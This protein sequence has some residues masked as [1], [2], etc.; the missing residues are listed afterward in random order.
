MRHTIIM[1]VIVS[2]HLAGSCS[3]LSYAADPSPAA[4]GQK[5]GNDVT[6]QKDVSSGNPLEEFAKSFGQ[7]VKSYAENNPGGMEQLADRY[8][9]TPLHS[10]A[11]GNKT[12]E[13]KRLLA[14]GADANARDFQ[15]STPLHYAAH[16][17]GADVIP[18]LLAAGADV[19]A[20]DQ[21]GD[22]P[23]HLAMPIDG[24]GGE[25]A[26]PYLLKG[27]ADV[28]AVDNDG[29]TP[30]LIGCSYSNLY[31]NKIKQLIAAGADVNRRSKNGFSPLHWA[32]CRH[33]ELVAVLIAAGAD[34]NAKDEEGG[35]PLHWAALHTMPETVE[36]LLKAKA[37]PNARDK[38][39]WSPLAL[40]ADNN[41]AEIVAVLRQAGGREE[42][43]TK[44][45]QAAVFEKP[46]KLAELL[47]GKPAVNATDVYG[48]TPLQWAL[49]CNDDK[50]ADVLIAA[51]ADLTT[52]DKQHK[53]ILQVAVWASRIDIVKKAIAAGADVNLADDDGYTALHF[54]ITSQNAEIVPLLLEKHAKV[55]L[56][57][58]SGDTPLLRAFPF[59]K[60]ELINKLLDAGADVQAVNNEGKSVRGQLWTVHDEKLRDRLEKAVQRAREE[61]IEAICRLYSA[62]NPR[63]DGVCA[64]TP[65]AAA[66]KMY[67]A[68][69]GPNRKAFLAMFVGQD[70]DMAAVNA[71][72]EATHAYLA[73]RAELTKA[74]GPDAWAKFDALKMA[75]TEWTIT[76]P[77]VADEAQLERM[78]V[79]VQGDQAVCRQFPQ[80]EKADVRFV[81]RD[82]VW[83]IDAGF[84][85]PILQPGAILR[86]LSI[87]S[88][89][90]QKGRVVIRQSNRQ[91][92]DVKRA[93]WKEFKQRH[94]AG[95]AGRDFDQQIADGTEAIRLDPKS[96]DAY[97]RRADSYLDKGDLDKALADYSEAIHLDPQ[98]TG[99]FIDRA[100]I[101]GIK[102]DC[103]RAM[104]DAVEAVRIDPTFAK[105][106]NALGIAYDGY[107]RKMS[108]LDAEAAD[109]LFD[110][111]AKTFGGPPPKLD[112]APRLL[113]F[114][115]FRDEDFKVAARKL[116]RA[117]KV[118]LLFDYSA[119]AYKAAIDIKPDYD[120]GNNNLGVYYARRGGLDDMKLAEKYLRAALRSNP[121]YADACNNLGIVLARQGKLDEA[122]AAHKT[123]LRARND[124]ASDH[125]NL[126]RVY[127][128]KGDLDSASQ[129]NTVSLR[130]DPNF[131]GAW[132][133]RAELGIKRKDVD[134]AA[135]CVHRMMAIDVKAPQTIQAE[136]LVAGVYLD[137][138][139]PE[140]A[141]DFLGDFLKHNPS[142]PDIYNA[143]GIAYLQKGDLIH[144][145]NDFEQI[146]RIRPNH[147]DAQK[148]LDAIQTQLDDWKKRTPSAEHDRR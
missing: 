28:N 30:L 14:A 11:S 102:G 87:L 54:A 116:D 119:A 78:E 62:D 23:L 95:E 99:A 110:R 94:E 67:R 37:D 72:Y 73:F 76:L 12:A 146:L 19:N 46:E 129:E 137:L 141:I 85:V 127:L 112:D 20:K 56:A 59:G 120:F 128:Q 115:G 1:L 96:A 24:G 38:K 29:Q 58:K 18:V 21:N 142:V 35:T 133:T 101:Y 55:N 7:A 61:Q 92:E 49:R 45:H 69:F 33:P 26:I 65:N 17:F 8:K 77:V 27:K 75:G 124:R 89:T 134:E 53:S 86:S 6:D 47:K 132:L 64:T 16:D 147:T 22:T 105:A 3:R 9:I 82:G 84:L 68:L 63:A 66:V 113:S 104:A 2:F 111:A 41:G 57:T 60:P 106:H 25:K 31:L 130:C 91:I 123:G 136:L 109:A 148:R 144:A 74:Y 100:K 118:Q 81:R 51:G 90:L 39:G 34:V 80:W 143:R 126:C 50:A 145:K 70:L 15:G 42:S 79:G 135:K 32:C 97:I 88:R 40:A 138:K 13:A 98:C 83:R 4:I 103:D 139:R 107:A 114:D 125:N 44:L 52:F 36:A 140:A 108:M 10:A 117:H 71:L 122:I 121:R 43:W 48:R 93:M 5:T 131:L